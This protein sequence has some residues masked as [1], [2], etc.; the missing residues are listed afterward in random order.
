[1]RTIFIAVAICLASIG[2][3]AAEELDYRVRP[4][5]AGGALKSLFVTFSF[6][7]EPDGDTVLRLPD[8][9]GGKERLYRAIRDLRIS[10]EGARLEAGD[11]PARPVI[12]HAPRARLSVSY[13]LVQIES[14]PAR[15]TA[16]PYEPLIQ[17]TYLHLIGHTVWVSPSFSDDVPLD[18]SLSLEGMPASWPVAASFAPDGLPFHG[19]LMFG[20]LKQSIL[21]AGDFRIAR[22]KT[23]EGPILIATRGQW[24]FSDAQFASL[25]LDATGAARRIFQSERE[26]PFLVTLIDLEPV[27]G[28]ISVGGTGLINSFAAF[29]T[30]GSELTDFEHLLVHEYLHHW[31]PAKLAAMPYENENA[32]YWFS[33]GFTDYVTWIARLK[34]GLIDFPRFVAQLNET[35]DAYDDSPVRE[36]PNEQ[37]AHDFWRDPYSKAMPYVRGR[38]FAFHLDAALRAESGG[39]VQ[40]IDALL[41]MYER[42]QRHP[43]ESPPPDA[44]LTAAIRHVA[45]LDTRGDIARFIVDGAPIVPTDAWLGDCAETYAAPFMTADF[46]LDAEETAA[47]KVITGVTPEGPA[48]AAGLSDGQKV[49]GMSMSTDNGRPTGS[50]RIAVMAGRERRD[51]TY[52]PSRATDRRV[53]RFRIRSETNAAELERCADYWRGQ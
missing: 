16:A 19:S 44:A 39:R 8:E 33:E 15:G 6:R 10:G 47:R 38:L 12:L 49:V 46:G 21:V 7:G 37:I 53:T 17:P 22:H 24:S 52:V 20:D 32:F 34:S 28:A 2:A 50:V 5:F 35:L 23:A 43:S 1:M 45:D 18:F 41:A 40:L 14:G 42:R 4:E 27:G 13:R 9:W 29:A 3:S 11:S 48:A 36:A 31:F 25:V 30:Q 26:P 51:V